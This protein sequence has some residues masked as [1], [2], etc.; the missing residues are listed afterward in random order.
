[1]N[2]IIVS[3]LC[4]ELEKAVSL[5]F[6]YLAVTCFIQYLPVIM[7]E[8]GADRENCFHAYLMVYDLTKVNF[9]E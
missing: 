4:S 8:Q 9:L 1:M 5:L 7:W 3:Q 2:L 6:F